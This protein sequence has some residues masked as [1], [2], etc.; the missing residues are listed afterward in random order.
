M[1]CIV[2]IAQGGKVYMGGDSAGV[3]GY[4]LTIRAD[5][6]VFINDG[7]LMGFTSSFRMG[8]LLQYALKPPHPQ[9]KADLMRFMATEFIDVVRNTLKAGGYASKENETES[10]GCFLVGYLGRLFRVHS[11]YQVAESAYGFDAVGCGESYAAGSLHATPKLEPKKR[12]LLA[13]EVAEKC[14][15]GVRAPFHVMSLWQSKP[16]KST[17]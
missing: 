10:G 17:D 8:Q 16:I 2:G 14:S 15:A 4:D 12:V 13:L 6:K 3:G 9:E 11:D 5:R 7:F 1:T